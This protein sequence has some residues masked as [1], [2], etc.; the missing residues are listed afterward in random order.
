MIV[1]LCYARSGGTILNKCLA[2]LPHV[3]MLSEVN[4]LGGGWGELGENSYTTVTEQAFYWYNIK[5]NQSYFKESIVEL[6]QYCKSNGKT[7]II[8]DW[9][10]VNFSKHP[11]NNYNPPNKFLT[12][13]KLN[14]QNINIFAFIRDAI[15]V[16]ISRGMPD[17]ETF[18][19]EY[20]EYLKELLRLK[21]PIFKYETFTRR[22][23]VTL[24][25]ICNTI[26]VPYDKSI[27][28]DCLNY[29]KVNGDN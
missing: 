25:K 20:Y 21:V 16:W 29:K 2:S 18:Y 3:V 8:R 27:F 5:L 1:M 10:F 12:I 11:D 4:P 19:S 7:L 28:W 14:N 15:D 13:E 24:R 6:N 22:P 23:R 17:T 9:S 26:D